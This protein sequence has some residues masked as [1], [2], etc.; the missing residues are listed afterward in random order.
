M[1]LGCEPLRHEVL[2]VPPSDAI[3]VLSHGLEKVLAE[4][5]IHPLNTGGH[6][7]FPKV[8]QHIHQPQEVNFARMAAFVPPREDQ[9]MFER[10]KRTD[11]SYATSTSS[12]SGILA[13]IYYLL[14]TFR[15]LDTSSLSTRELSQISTF[16]RGSGRA[17]SALLIPLGLTNHEGQ[18]VYAIDKASDKTIKRNS[19]LMDLGKSLERFLCMEPKQFEANFVKNSVHYMSDE[20][21]V[22]GGF[23]EKDCYL[24]SRAGPFMLRSQLDC[25]DESLP[26]TTHSQLLGGGGDGCEGQ[27]VL[28]SPPGSVLFRSFDLKTRATLAI[29]H[30]VENYEHYTDY[31]IVQLWGEENS[32]EREFYDMIRSAFIK[33][34]CQSRIGRMAGIMVAYHNTREMFGFEF[35]PQEHMDRL[36]YGSV[37]MADFAFDSSLKLLDATITRILEDYPDCDESLQLLFKTCEQGFMEVFVVRHQ[38]LDAVLADPIAQR[39][40]LKHYRVLTDSF[41]NSKRALD[42]SEFRPGDHL[43]VNYSVFNVGGQGKNVST[44]CSIASA[45]RFVR[46]FH[47]DE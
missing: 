15:P 25:Y 33:Y 10:I 18:P 23:Q 12:I 35:V 36:V 34:G 24:Y 39:V 8:L 26:G 16:T 5:G 46:C 43:D 28:A 44:G 38:H 42:Y 20:E 32:F 45:Y 3:L 2:E 9:A 19:I 13:H 11:C 29:R 31:R 27:A 21:F 37:A 17:T 22:S 41:L 4:P 40:Y 14:S 30:N 7:H 1:S 6:Y 47:E